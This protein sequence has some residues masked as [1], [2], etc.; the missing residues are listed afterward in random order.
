[1]YKRVI[2]CWEREVEKGSGGERRGSNKND[3]D[4]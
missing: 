2:T 4:M 1:M 3:K